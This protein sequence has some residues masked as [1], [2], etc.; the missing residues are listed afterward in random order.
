MRIGKWRYGIELTYDNIIG[1]FICLKIWL[2]LFNPK[3]LN[4]SKML[5]VKYL[6]L[7]L[8]GKEWRGKK[9]VV[10]C[11]WNERDTKGEINQNMISMEIITKRRMFLKS[12]HSIRF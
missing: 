10:G 2:Y 8:M 1:L 5:R 11:I 3:K 7:F 9:V 12:S 6:W 4:V